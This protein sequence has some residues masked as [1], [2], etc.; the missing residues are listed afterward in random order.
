MTWSSICLFRDA[1]AGKLRKFA[2]RRVAR[3]E[4]GEPPQLQG[5]R[6][7]DSLLP[8][9]FPASGTLICLG[10][11]TAPGLFSEGGGSKLPA[12]CPARDNKCC[13]PDWG[14]E[15]SCLRQLLG[16]GGWGWG[17]LRGECV[18]PQTSALTS[19]KLRHR[20]IL[21][22]LSFRGSPIF[23]SGQ[24]QIARREEWSGR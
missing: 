16:G 3:R 2:E 9:S 22:A 10:T 24:Q 12:W 14:E 11:N 13:E 8:A 19:Y 18:R 5:N 17:G 23:H 15:P 21:V 6:A 7:A 20:R 1:S 4:L